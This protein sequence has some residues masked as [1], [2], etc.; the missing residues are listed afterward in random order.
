MALLI[1]GLELPPDH[2][3]DAPLSAALRRLRA[4][5]QVLGGWS[6]VRSSVDVR[7]RGEPR[8]VYTVRLVLERAGDEERLARSAAARQVAIEVPHPAWEPRPGA[9]E[10]R[11]QVVVL[12]SGPAGLAA[13]WRLAAAGYRP[14][15]LERGAAVAGRKAALAGLDGAGRLDAETNYCFGE[16][17]AGCFSDGKL[18]TRRADPRGRE[19]LELLVDCGAPAELLTEG[20]PHVGSDRLP[21]VVCALAGRIAALGGRLRTGARV[22]A[23]ETADGR[24][25]ALRLADGERIETGA[26]VLACGASARDTFAALL[27]A[28][29]PLE[30]RPLQMGLRLECPQ[31]EVDSLLHGRWAGQARLGPAEFFLRSPAE[32]GCAAAHTFCMCPGGAV[33]PV[34]TEP[35]GLG[36]NGASRRCRGSGLANAAVISAVPAGSAPLEGV[37]LQRRLERLVWERGGADLSF[38]CC[39]VRDFLRGGTLSPLPAAAGAV[40]RR[41]ARLDG[42]LPEAT[43]AAV[44][45]ALQRFAGVMP[46]LGGALAVLYGAEIRVGSPVRLPR[47]AAGRAAGADNLFPAGEGPG[48]AAGIMS[49]AIDGLRA[50]ENLVAGFAA[51]R[52]E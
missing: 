9:R 39:T 27:A 4:G 26:C 28:G 34:C 15:V 50:G 3:E 51:P 52:A 10:L 6:V 44:R 33:V 2:E 37:E 11:G 43:E 32:A 5:A 46:L 16:G 18:H 23:F 8:L 47:D 13:A 20:R 24:L 29:L 49:S 36:T 31:P 12:G 41:A 1:S 38:P 42:L 30:P 7:R 14:L 19:F 21:A 40:R 35:E 25:T 48:H 45:R 17:G 22:A